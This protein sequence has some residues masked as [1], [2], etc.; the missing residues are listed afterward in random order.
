MKRLL[1]LFL[2]TL[3]GAALGEVAATDDAGKLVRLARPAAR[4][5]SLS[6]HVTEL[7]YAA[8][9]GERVVAA[10]EYSDH[11]EAAKKLPRIGSYAAL[12]LERIATLKPD[13][14][15]AWG[16]GN[17]PAQVAQLARLGIP[18][19]VS[20]PKKLEDIPATLR[21]L[22]RLTASA[23]A[24][25][26]AR[27]FERRHAA[28]SEKYAG[29]RSVGVF[30]EIWNQPLMTVGGEHVISAAITLCGGRNVFARLTQPAEAVEL[31]AV[32]R[33]DPEAIVSGGMETVRREWLEQWRRWPQLTAVKRGNLFVVPPDLLQRHTPRLL[34]GAER[35]CEAL[36]TARQRAVQTGK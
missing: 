24:E 12:D 25:T 13:L 21:R 8:G 31:E 28:L 20:E 14:A 19:F 4:I 27:D 36:E 3:S 17:P 5:V 33:A 34:E 9:A 10:V 30:Y 1:A 26:A 32:L 11:P 2:L 29:R 23:A 7:L 22:G 16:S 6:P 35:L 18:V 15:V